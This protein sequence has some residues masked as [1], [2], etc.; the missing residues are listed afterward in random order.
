MLF[1]NQGRAQGGM[2]A[3]IINAYFL[4]YQFHILK[5]T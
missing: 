5:L 1:R 4:Y 2:I 3:S